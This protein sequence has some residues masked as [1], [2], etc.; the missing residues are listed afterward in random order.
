MDFEDFRPVT[1]GDRQAIMEVYK[2]H[3]P[4]HSDYSFTTMF[5]WRHYMDYMFFHLGE[6][7]HFMTRKD[8]DATFRGPIGNYGREDIQE[9]LDLAFREGGDPP[10]GV[11]DRR[12]CEAIGVVRP[13][14]EFVPRREYFDYVYLS[15][16]LRDLRGGD[17]LN[18]RNQLNHYKKNNDRSFEAIGADNIVEAREFFAWWCRMRGCEK[19][20][21]LESEK[22][23]I[24]TCM[25]N[26]EALELKGIMVRIEGEIRAASVFDE[27]SSD[28]AVIH[29][30]KADP[31][32]KGLY[33]A[34][35]QQ[36]AS[37]LSE[38]YRFI[39]RESDMGIPGLR[40]AK[41][42]YRPHHMVEVYQVPI[43]RPYNDRKIE[44]KRRMPDEWAVEGSK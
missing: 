17:F 29:I 10:L 7:I 20:P 40:H 24:R 16:S 39:N 42:R 30:E 18:H 26:F 5:A 21:L 6:A 44:K 19:E 14:L 41:E 1:L 25:D 31:R 15:T 38:K 8:G 32:I 4:L 9:L 3:A 35:N 11:L 12:M 13:D 27:L 43:A 36:T 33:Q 37:I 34:I 22:T 28:T 2:D 23:F